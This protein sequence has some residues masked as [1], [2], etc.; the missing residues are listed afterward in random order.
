M[1]CAF[2]LVMQAGLLGMSA[3]SFLAR[4]HQGTWCSA[5]CPATGAPNCRVAC[6]GLGSCGVARGLAPWHVVGFVQAM[7]YPRG[8]LQE[9]LQPLADWMPCLTTE[10]VALCVHHPSI[11]IIFIHYP[12]KP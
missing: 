4:T 12:F 7:A 6:K 3:A 8:F 1:W 10:W 5:G 11:I 9:R 2:M